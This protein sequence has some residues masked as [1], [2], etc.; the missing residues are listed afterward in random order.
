M[1]E[2]HNLFVCM[3]HVLIQFFTAREKLWVMQIIVRESNYFSLS[4][5]KIAYN[6]TDLRSV[7]HMSSFNKYTA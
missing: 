1:M 4:P 6:P 5:H 7:F 3:T 2:L